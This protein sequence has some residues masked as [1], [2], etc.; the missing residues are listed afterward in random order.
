MVLQK[1]M[2]YET[3]RWEQRW[4]SGRGVSRRRAVAGGSDV[5]GGEVPGVIKAVKLLQLNR[6]TPDTSHELARGF[7]TVNYPAYTGR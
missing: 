6:I 2:C 1:V 3:L 4:L 7:Y 5:G